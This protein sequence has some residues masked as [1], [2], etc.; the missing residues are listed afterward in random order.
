MSSAPFSPKASLPHLILLCVLLQHFS[1]SF[2]TSKPS[3]IHS[4][5]M[6]KGAS[7]LAG[8]DIQGWTFPTHPVVPYQAM[9]T[10][11]ASSIPGLPLD[12]NVM[13]GASDSKSPRTTL[14][15]LA[16][17][18][19]SRYTTYNT[20]APSHAT[21]TKISHDR[22]HSDTPSSRAWSEYSPPQPSQVVQHPYDAMPWASPDD[23]KDRQMYDFPQTFFGAEGLPQGGL[24]LNG[25]DRMSYAQPFPQWEDRTPPADPDLMEKIK[26]RRHIW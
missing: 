12:N 9:T 23:R 8:A 14:P 15:L 10:M 5:T 24:M 16:P 22:S 21:L 25:Q 6:S 17:M 11:T 18:D 3:T 4:L 1:L 7:N 2:T 19:L 20:P 13:D 26:S